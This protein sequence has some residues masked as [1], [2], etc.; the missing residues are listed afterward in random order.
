L[1]HRS[2]FSSNVSLKYRAHPDLGIPEYGIEDALPDTMA[3]RIKSKK[4]L[5]PDVPPPVMRKHQNLVIAGIGVFCTTVVIAAVVFVFSV[6]D[7][8]SVLAEE[9]QPPRLL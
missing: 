9:T 7:Q 4:I 1:R 2:Q 6:P 8:P 5:I 3:L